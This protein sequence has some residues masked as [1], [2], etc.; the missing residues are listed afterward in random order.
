MLIVKLLND[1]KISQ[2]RNTVSSLCFTEEIKT[3]ML[4]SQNHMDKI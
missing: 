3:Q 2:I 4:F 1:I